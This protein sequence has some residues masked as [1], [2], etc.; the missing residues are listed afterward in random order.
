[1]AY[2]RSSKGPE[3]SVSYFQIFMADLTLRSQGL[4][5]PEGCP[6]CEKVVWSQETEFRS[7]VLRIGREQA[8]H[9]VAAERNKSV[10]HWDE[11][12]NDV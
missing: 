2:G 7:G 12:K 10:V 11:R 8:L 3:N 6:L 4:A 1:M 9:D 5:L